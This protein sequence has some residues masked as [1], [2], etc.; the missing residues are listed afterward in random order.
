MSHRKA[1]TIRKTLRSSGIAAGQTA[2]HIP[3][4]MNKRIIQSGI[5][6]D[7]AP[8]LREFIYTG[9]VAMVPDCGRRFYKA[10]KRVGVS[11]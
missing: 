5:G 7:G 6:K 11:A 10:V 3:G 2:Y 8:I 1:K 4:G 9:T